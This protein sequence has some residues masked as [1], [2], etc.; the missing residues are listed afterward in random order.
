MPPLPRRVDALLADA[1]AK[2]N[3]LGDP[4]DRVL[5][6]SP[7]SPERKAAEQAVAALQALSDGLVAAGNK[8]GVLVLVP[9]G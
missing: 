7:G 8:L 3:A 1:E 4:W 5:A 6:A 2:L 9:N